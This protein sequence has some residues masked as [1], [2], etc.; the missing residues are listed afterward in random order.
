MSRK[1]RLLTT[2][3]CLLCHDLRVR[4]ERAAPLLG[5]T[6]DVVDLADEPDGDVYAERVPVVIDRGV[7]V[8]EGRVGALRMMATLARTWLPRS[9]R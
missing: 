4:L 1:V 3:A 2:P 7:V 8:A 9:S 5:V 6:V